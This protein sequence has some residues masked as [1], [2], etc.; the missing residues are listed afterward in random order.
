MTDTFV[1]IM[2]D[3]DASLQIQTMMYEYELIACFFDF[4]TLTS[5][6]L[7]DF[8]SCSSSGFFNVLKRL[9]GR[10]VIHSE[11]HPTDKRSKVYRLSETA[12]EYI[13]RGRVH[14]GVATFE[15]WRGV[16][17]N[18]N[19]LRT[20]SANMRR[21]MGIRHLT[22]E[23]Q[24]LLSLYYRSGIT[25]MEFTEYHRHVADEVQSQLTR[26]FRDGPDLR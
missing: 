15:E 12:A 10:R 18:T 14:Y 21:T 16:S 17:G 26:S 25:N 9:E 24:I 20:Y 3:V 23:Y 13:R 7:A 11:P 8:S 2:R 4:D 5:H 6:Q 1:G 22:C 19:L